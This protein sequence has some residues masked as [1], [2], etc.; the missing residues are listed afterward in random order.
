[1][2]LY[3]DTMGENCYSIAIC[4]RCKMKRKYSELVE[5]PNSKLRVCIYGCADELDPYRL[6][7]RKTE[8][9]SLQYPRPDEDLVNP[10]PPYDPT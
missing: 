2:P 9:I 3:L 5:D 4:G 10:D 8:D 6:P 1:M 7:T